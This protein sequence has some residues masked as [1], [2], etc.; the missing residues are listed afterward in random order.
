MQLC[1]CSSGVSCIPIVG[2]LDASA[3]VF[4]AHTRDSGSVRSQKP[5]CCL[6]C[7]PRICCLT[8]Y[9]HVQG[10]HYRAAGG[11]PQAHEGAQCRH[12]QYEPW[13]S[14]AKRPLIHV[15]WSRPKTATRASTLLLATP[16]EVNSPAASRSTPIDSLQNTLAAS[17]ARPA[18]Q[19]SRTTRP[20]Y[21][22]TDATS[23]KLRSSSTA[24]GSCSSRVSRMFQLSKSGQWT[25]L[26]G[27][28]SLLWIPEW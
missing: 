25:V 27:A 15:Q 13:P 20:P 28:R 21:P 16:V 6:S 4:V 24:T 5:L 10:Q 12:L 1:H 8:C 19:S 3:T 17:R 2:A 7:F 23:T 26:R 14:N 18:T 9:R 11:A 22:P